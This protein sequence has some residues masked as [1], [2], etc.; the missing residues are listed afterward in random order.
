MTE[1]KGTINRLALV[2]SMQRANFDLLRFAD[3]KAQFLLR[4]SLGMFAV[5]FVG[6]PP[7]VINLKQSAS[8]GGTAFGVFIVVLILYL[9][10]TGCLIVSLTKIVA[11]IRPRESEL[12]DAPSAL[13]FGSIAKMEHGA[14]R[15]MIHDID[16]DRALDEIIRS[17]YDTS[18]IAQAKF[19]RI[20]DAISWMLG[21]GLI[22]VFFT[23]V[24]LISMGLAW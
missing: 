20:A 1:G 3:T 12:E 22:G 24:L 18:N 23:L 4:I 13:Y 10:C 5:A 6:V 7:L 9:F 14:F 17:V 15:E 11:V 21:G 2:E 8:N 19:D 16:P